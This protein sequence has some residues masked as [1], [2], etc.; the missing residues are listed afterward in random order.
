MIHPRRTVP[1]SLKE[2]V[3][4]VIVTKSSVERVS[5]TAVTAHVYA[6]IGGSS[7]LALTKATR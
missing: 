1:R 4:V 2:A 5:I 6:A 7:K 3:L